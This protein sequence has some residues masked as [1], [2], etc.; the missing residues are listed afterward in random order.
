[1]LHRSVQL[2]PIVI[3]GR[4]FRSVLHY[5]ARLAQTIG[6]LAIF[7]GFLSQLVLLVL[8]SEA[9]RVKQLQVVGAHVRAGQRT[10]EWIGLLLVIHLKINEEVCNRRFDSTL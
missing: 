5:L 3:F 2:L 6:V 1:M 10:D 9:G 8:I 4:D 7:V